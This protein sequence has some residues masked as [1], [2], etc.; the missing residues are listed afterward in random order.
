MRCF[1]RSA[2]IAFTRSMPAGVV[3]GDEH[4]AVAGQH[5]HNPILI[6]VA[7]AT[8]FEASGLHH[9]LDLP[10]KVVDVQ[11]DAA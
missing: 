2:E 9:I 5:W 1:F 11:R 10:C 8:Y 6:L 7:E 3:K 4:A